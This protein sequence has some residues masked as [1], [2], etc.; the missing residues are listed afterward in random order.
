[1]STNKNTFKYLCLVFGAA[2]TH[3]IIRALI[4]EFVPDTWQYSQLLYI[5]LSDIP[6]T[7]VILCS[8]LYYSGKFTGFPLSAKQKKPLLTAILGCIVLTL[9][10][11]VI[12]LFILM[13]SIMLL[14]FINHFALPVIQLLG[15]MLIMLLGF[16]LCK[17]VVGKNKV[18]FPRGMFC[19]LS[20]FPAIIYFLLGIIL[21]LIDNSIASTDH[22]GLGTFFLFYFFALYAH[23]HE[24]CIGW[25]IFCMLKYNQSMKIKAL[26]EMQAK[27]L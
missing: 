3:L 11:A 2:L 5:F 12:N 20:A 23:I 8:F 1:M 25:S 10:I 6:L 9:L 27:L 24:I 15:V 4:W 17:L 26:L 16:V 21:V 18:F 22:S 13:A 19:V 7:T 14:S